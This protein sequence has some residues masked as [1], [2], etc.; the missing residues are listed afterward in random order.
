MP[1]RFIAGVMLGAAVA[2]ACNP[3]GTPTSAP[4]TPTTAPVVTAAPATPAATTGTPTSAGAT[5]KP[6]AGGTPAVEGSATLEAK[7]GKTAV[8]IAVTSSGTEAMAASIQAGTCD[9]LNPEIAYRLTD[10]T[11]GASSTTVDVA[12]A[13]LLATPYSINISVLGSETESS[14]T[15][16]EIVA[17]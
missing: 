16:G 13:T 2:T 11:G 9:N 7:D 5:F 10:V 3:A 15:C 14:I 12:L 17:R 4:A 8:I 6:K 1:R